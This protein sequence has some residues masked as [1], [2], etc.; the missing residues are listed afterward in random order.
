MVAF[1]RMSVEQLREYQREAQRRSRARTAG[2]PDAEPKYKRG[3][4]ADAVPL[5]DGPIFSAGTPSARPSERL[6]AEARL[7]RSAAMSLTAT[8]MGD[9]PPGQSALDKRMSV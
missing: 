3:P 1:S 2:A 9:P 7:R 8:L 4:V 6:I 5:A